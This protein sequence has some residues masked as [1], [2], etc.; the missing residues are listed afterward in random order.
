MQVRV[1]EVNVQCTITLLYCGKNVTTVYSFPD[2]V[3]LEEAFLPLA[4]HLE[5]HSFSGTTMSLKLS[6]R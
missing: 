4:Y 3:G 6:S 1:K 2:T 5:R